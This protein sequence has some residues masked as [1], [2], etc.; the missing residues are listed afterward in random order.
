MSFFA[1]DACLRGTGGICQGHYF[2]FRFP[3]FVFG[4]AR[5]VHIAHLELLA[6][7]VGVKVWRHVI[8]GNR[9]VVGCDNQAVVTIIN[10]GRS[11]NKLL[12]KMLC[13]LCYQLAM[14]EAEIFAKNYRRYTEHNT[15]YFE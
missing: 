6:I 14:V 5:K 4:W 3:E 2:H 9:F 12:Q 8:R 10:T 15:G 1:T 13:E 11:K 7:I